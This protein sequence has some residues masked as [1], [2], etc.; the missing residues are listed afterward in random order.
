MYIVIHVSFVCFQF[1][2]RDFFVQGKYLHHHKGGPL[3]PSIYPSILL[4]LQREWNST[5]SFQQ[6]ATIGF[7]KM[8]EEVIE[9]E[10]EGS[11]R[12]ASSAAALVWVRKDETYSLHVEVVETPTGWGHS[13]KDASPT[14]SSPL[15]RQL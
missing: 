13:E 12:L 4:F 8:E 11:Y 14:L 3:I 15:P 10:E 9:E 6:C 1:L 2:P 5:A 7:L